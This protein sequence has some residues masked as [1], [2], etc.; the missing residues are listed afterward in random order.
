MD[1]WTFVYDWWRRFGTERVLHPTAHDVLMAAP[2]LGD[3]FRQVG[4]IPASRQGVTAAL[5][6]RVRCDHLAG[7]RRR[8]DAQL[9]PAR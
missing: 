2:G 5:R 9:A 1:A 7:G 4:V 8:R 3:Y 6:L